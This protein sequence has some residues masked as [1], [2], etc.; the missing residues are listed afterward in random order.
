L[1]EAICVEAQA[2]SEEGS[3]GRLL[4]GY[5][6]R[7][8]TEQPAAGSLPLS[9]VG[10]VVLNLTGPA[11][12]A[13]VTERPTMAPESHFDGSVTQR[14]LRET[15]ASELLAQVARGAASLWL[16][17]LLPLMRGSKTPGTMAG[18]KR[19]AA[20]LTAERDRDILAR[21]TLTFSNLAGNRNIWQRA[22]EGW[23]MLR[24]E[25]MDEL[26]IQ[27]RIDG[28]RDL[29]LYQGRE[30]FGRSPTKRQ[31]AEIDAINDP[32]RLKDLSGRLLEVS[33]WAELLAVPRENGAD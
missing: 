4:Y 22:L 15:D 9:A 8:R 13:T 2:E 19:E 26:R 1:F 17:A 18:W 23:T 29:L 11:C 33:T 25:Y 3:A 30:K 5:L 32:D 7:L 28:M 14:T 12:R 21:L 6:P 10:G 31:Q 27:V 20:K 16:V 24:S